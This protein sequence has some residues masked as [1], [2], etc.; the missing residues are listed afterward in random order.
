MKPM[1]SRTVWVIC[2]ALIF[3]GFFSC[4]VSAKVDVSLNIELD[5]DE[6]DSGDSFDVKLTI[7]N[8]DTE[9]L[10]DADIEIAIY[11][12]DTLVHED[13]EHDIDVLQNSSKII[14]TISSTKFETDDGYIW[15]KA[16]MGYECVKKTVEVKLSGDVSES[17]TATLD[18][19][20][21]KLY[22]GMK[23]VKPTPGSEIVV[24][25]EDEDGD[26]LDYVYVRITHLG[27][28]E[29][30]DSEDV[31]RE[32]KT[33]DGEVTFDPLDE[34]FRFKDNPYGEYQLDVWDDDYCLF[35][36]T[37]EVSNKLK[38]TEVP[39]NPYAGEEIRVKVLDIDD[40]RV[41]NAK[42]AVSGSE[43]FVDSYKSD[44][45]GYVRFTLDKIGS[46][47]LIA[48]KNGYEDSDIVTINVKIKEG[49][50]IEIEPIK[51]AIDKD[52]VIT[53][54]SDGGPIESAEVTIK[55]P[56]GKTDVLS[57]SSAGKVTYKPALPGTYDITVKKT[58]YET[59]TS[60]FNAMNF[61][62]I[63]IPEEPE[64]YEEISVVVKNQDGDPVE[65]ASVGLIG[66]DITGLT[67]TEGKF[68][69]ILENAGEY[70]LSVK[71]G[72]YEDFSK[73][74]SIQGGLQLKVTPNVLD[75]GDSVAIEVLDENGERIEVN[76]QIIKPE[77]VKETIVKSSHTFVPELAGRYNITA[78]KNYYAS[79][80][81]SFEVNPYSL[82]LDVWLSG[83]DL[84]VKA[85]SE[86]EIVQNISIS[87]LMPNGDEILLTT[88]N[89]GIAKLDIEELNQTGTFV[90]SSV[91]RNYEKKTITK[92]IKSLGGG[93]M[94]ILLVLVA[95]IF[96]LIL[97]GVVLYISHK[98]G[99]STKR[100]ER[101]KGTGLGGL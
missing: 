41:E 58:A 46:Y 14:A 99:K 90:M 65:G 61:F 29:R 88:D 70:T 24:E 25:V 9:N 52:V 55:R 2:F 63:M 86:G 67:N 79:E 32:K 68:I 89:L 53:V 33:D 34:D 98:K 78:S 57:T 19:D 42:I 59:T 30:W 8:T 18:I 6:I 101:K 27:D 97:I 7:D 48:S 71:R 39:E 36:D 37:F 93:L 51:Q 10:T 50:N 17:D 54:T 84:T 11:V 87:V 44:V 35:R 38:I 1:I 20:G 81:S 15:E 72:G 95:V 100:T 91:E 62:D 69:F 47:T 23:P 22:V 92:D 45:D 31:Y 96:L 4:F 16:L 13:V 26:P 56:D 12:G 5:P 43:G 76:I 80:S 64:L 40:K 74:I 75:I 21:K 85:T 94:P 73:K 77:G 83:K 49:M 3:A 28:N 60:S 66:A 82:D